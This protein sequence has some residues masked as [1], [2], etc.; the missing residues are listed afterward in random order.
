MFR[1]GEDNKQKLFMNPN[2]ISRAGEEYFEPDPA[3]QC[4]LDF[5]VLIR[6]KISLRMTIYN[7][8]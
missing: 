3:Q 6:K 7:Q 1:E 5:E 2:I 4:F 8:A